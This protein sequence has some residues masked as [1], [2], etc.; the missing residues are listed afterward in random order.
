VTSCEPIHPSLT[1]RRHVIDLAIPIPL[2]S[3]QL[4]ESRKL[5]Y[6]PV[7]SNRFVF[8]FDPGRKEVGISVVVLV[9][10]PFFDCLVKRPVPV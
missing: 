7:P 1:A 9:S 5:V 10:I 6:L 8:K 2:H 4:E 3:D